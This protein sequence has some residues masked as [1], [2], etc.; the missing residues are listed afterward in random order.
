MAL[1]TE[2]RSTTIWSE[3]RPCARRSPFPPSRWRATLIGSTSGCRA[4]RIRPW[5]N[6]CLIT[7]MMRARSL[8][9]RRGRHAAACSGPSPTGWRATGGAPRR[10]APRVVRPC[11]ELAQLRT[12]DAGGAARSRRARRLLDVHLH[13]LAPHPPVTAGM[14]GEVRGCRIDHRRRAHPRVRLRA[15]P[16]QRGGAVEQ[17]RRPLPDRG[18]QDYG[19]WNESRTTTGPRST[20]PTLRAGSAI[21][22]SVRASTPEPRW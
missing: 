3:G 15:R 9:C 7:S 18:R 2:R 13:Q 16:P 5:R 22:T 21:T 4:E 20:S 1:R 10:G 12:A 17:P 19:V 8:R 11:D 6:S 14:G